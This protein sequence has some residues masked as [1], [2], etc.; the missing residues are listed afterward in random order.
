MS[1]Y[2]L[3][4]RK[5]PRMEV[6]KKLRLNTAEIPDRAK[7]SFKDQ[8]DIN[9]LMGR[10]LRGGSIDHFARH[11]AK[12]G[13]FPPQTFHEAMNTVRA[14]EE[15]FLD[16]PA[17]QRKRFGNDPALFLEFVQDEKN[18][19]EM[20]KLG[21]ALPAREPEA[22]PM[23]QVVDSDRKPVKLGGEIPVSARDG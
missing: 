15:M 17:A 19:D 22:V 21:L 18:L 20:R 6:R 16:L 11:G 12:Y 5:A 2:G 14:A 23:V 8:S 3:F 13:E 7:Q 4:D 9:V 1:M 10:Y